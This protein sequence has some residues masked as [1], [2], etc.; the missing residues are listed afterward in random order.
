MVTKYDGRVGA[1]A[2]AANTTVNI[3]PAVAD[4]TMKTVTV[5]EWDAGTTIE[6]GIREFQSSGSHQPRTDQLLCE[7]TQTEER[8]TVTYSIDPTVVLVGDPQDPNPFLDGL[9]EGDTVYIGRRDGLPHDAA[10]ASGQRIFMWR[11][12]VVLVEPMGV[13]ANAD[14]SKYEAR[15]TWA[16]KA[17]ERLATISA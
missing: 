17:F 16:V 4:S 1:I 2:V 6:C 12:E 11:A 8:G 9:V 7:P 5:S 10:G 13:A 3:M 15:I 14:G